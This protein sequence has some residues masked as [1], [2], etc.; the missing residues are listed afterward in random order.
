MVTSWKKKFPRNRGQNVYKE[1]GKQ[2][3]DTAYCGLGNYFE[4]HNFSAFK[5]SILIQLY[6]SVNGKNPYPQV[7]QIIL[8]IVKYA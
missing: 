8:N 1:I 2:E 7:L 4:E 6:S 5:D 3:N